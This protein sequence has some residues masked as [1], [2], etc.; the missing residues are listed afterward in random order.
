MLD[1][2]GWLK[3]TICRELEDLQLF[4]YYDGKIILFHFMKS[5]T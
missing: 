1:V 5:Q 2:S 3:A 4:G